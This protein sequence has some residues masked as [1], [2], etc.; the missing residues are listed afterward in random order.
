VWT[1]PRDVEVPPPPWR[2]IAVGAVV[3]L[4]VGGGAAAL[5][6]PEVQEGK[7]ERAEEER[8]REAASE[9]ARQKELAR[10]SKPRFG[11]SERPTGRL[12]PTEERR[13]RRA[14]VRDVERA[15]TRDA[16]AR[17]RAG[18]L[19]GPVLDTT[20]EIN[21]PSRRPLERDLG[22]RRMDYQCLAITARDPGGQFIVGQTFEAT[23]DYER[24]RYRW[25]R[26]CYPPGEGSA[27]M[28]C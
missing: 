22:V 21:P 13:A 20:C 11:R 23:V 27:R 17:A 16:R 2:K 1:P 8:R 4:L 24:S 25:A 12:S 18:R 3:A 10:E 19:D 14:L 9:A 7:E 28:T 6:V 26:V 5:I 15:I